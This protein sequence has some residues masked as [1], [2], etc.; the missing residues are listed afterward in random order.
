ME[1]EERI[2]ALG[3]VETEWDPPL[4][5]SFAQLDE[6]GDGPDDEQQQPQ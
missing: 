1:A 2:R 6:Y 4:A 5:G 3:Q